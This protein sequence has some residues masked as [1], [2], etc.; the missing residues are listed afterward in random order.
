MLKEKRTILLFC[1]EIGLIIHVILIS[2]YFL[3][4]NIYGYTEIGKYTITSIHTKDLESVK[5]LKK[6]DLVI[7]NKEAKIKEKST[8]YYYTIIDETYQI[9]SD[10]VVEI[11]GKGKNKIYTVGE[12]NL[13]I[14][15]E[16]TLGKK[17]FA[18]PFLGLLVNACETKI[19]FFLLVLFP[20]ILFIIYHI[21][22]LKKIEKKKV[23]TKKEKNKKIKMR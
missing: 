10:K 9:Q 14:S 12:N 6:N 8:L 20:I 19:G 5:E 13:T 23:H 18:I 1:L 17:V 21:L 4:K 15:K 22:T 2:I 16:K 11:I 3:N 7:F